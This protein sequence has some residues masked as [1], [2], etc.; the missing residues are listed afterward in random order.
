MHELLRGNDTSPC[1][2]KNK[3]KKATG[4]NNDLLQSVRN[5]C[6]VLQAKK[7]VHAQNYTEVDNSC[8]RR[9]STGFINV[10]PLVAQTD[11]V[12][13]YSCTA[14]QPSSNQVCLWAEDNTHTHTHTLCRK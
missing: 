12:K 6:S 3:G 2:A 11:A 4:S 8:M 1:I 10:N 5:V 14:D 13:G 9:L 7:V